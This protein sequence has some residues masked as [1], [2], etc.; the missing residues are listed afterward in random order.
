MTDKKVISLLRPKDKIREE[1]NTFIEN[2][3]FE[4][5]GILM[6]YCDNL[7]E[8]DPNYTALSTYQPGMQEVIILQM[9]VEYL[10]DLL[11]GFE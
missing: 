9:A 3:D 7:D 6:F 11:Y 8:P 1:V 2:V 5:G 4:K 10:R